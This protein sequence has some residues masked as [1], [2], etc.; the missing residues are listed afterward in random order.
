MNAFNQRTVELNQ[1]VAA[2]TDDMRKKHKKQAE[3]LARKQN[4]EKQLTGAHSLGYK[5]AGEMARLLESQTV[6]KCELENYHNS[7]FR[8]LSDDQK[9]IE[10]DYAKELQR[11]KN[12][13]DQKKIYEMFAREILGHAEKKDQIEN[14]HLLAVE[15]TAELARLD[16]L[17]RL[18][19][20]DEE[21][22]HLYSLIAERMHA[23][24][25]E[26]VAQIENDHLLAVEMTAELAR[27]D[28]LARLA[29][30]DEEEKASA[31][32]LKFKAREED[33]FYGLTA[34]EQEMYLRLEDENAK[35][36]A[37]AEEHYE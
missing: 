29:K 28:K 19:K 4:K 6:E 24:Y 9:R 1:N 10:A 34:E 37:R 33:G 13:H 22:T 35:M 16:K 2:N 36:L 3:D 14:D 20:E 11:K 21:E 12:S 8:F 7:L 25:N 30:E 17:A 32:Y 23:A 5:H 18:A 31:L 15:M 26:R 27:L